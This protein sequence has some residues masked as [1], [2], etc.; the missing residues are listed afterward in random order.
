[1]KLKNKLIIL[2]FIL[3]GGC[4]YQPLLTSNKMGDFYIKNINFTGDK[5]LN[6]FLKINLKKYSE[7]TVGEKIQVDVNTEYYK[8]EISKNA[9]GSV[10]KFEITAKAVFFV[11][12][13]NSQKNKII[14]N[15]SFTMDRQ[16]DLNSEIRYERIIKQNFASSISNKLIIKL[17]KK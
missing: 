6:N 11:T 8:N 3:I 1:M 14:I 9:S 10:E 5:E 17:I 4:G 16:D 13:Q 15:E 7:N 2:I 12:D